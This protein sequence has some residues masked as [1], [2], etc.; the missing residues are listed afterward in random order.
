MSLTSSDSGRLLDSSMGA[1]I[2]APARTRTLA[3]P[4]SSRWTGHIVLAPWGR[5]DLDEI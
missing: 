5:L 4:S 1:S 2:M 3:G